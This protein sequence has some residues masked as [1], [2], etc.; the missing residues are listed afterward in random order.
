MEKEIKIWSWTIIWFNWKWWEA[1]GQ[2]C[3]VS[4]KYKAY[5]AYRH[6]SAKREKVYVFDNEGDF[7]DPCEL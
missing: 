5:D 4:N 2:V 1:P 3:H 7:I 6:L